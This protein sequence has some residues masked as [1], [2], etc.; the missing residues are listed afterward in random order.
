M[1]CHV[2]HFSQMC[3]ILLTPRIR[4]HLKRRLRSRNQSK[5]WTPAEM[6]LLD[7]MVECDV[8]QNL[9]KVTEFAKRYGFDGKKKTFKALNVRY[10]ER[11]AG[12]YPV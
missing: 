10:N 11:K 1:S 9:A 5:R 7:H 3:G 2:S 8:P 12:K 6:A 4:R